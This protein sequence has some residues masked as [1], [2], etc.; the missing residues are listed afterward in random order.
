MSQQKDAR[1]VELECH[2]EQLTTTLQLTEDKCRSVMSSLCLSLC[3]S[4]SVCVSVS[5]LQLKLVVN[6]TE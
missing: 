6:E 4:L 3:V 1:I 2:V 5:L